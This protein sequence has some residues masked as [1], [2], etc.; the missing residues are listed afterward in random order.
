MSTR[1]KNKNKRRLKKEI[2]KMDKKNTVRK[3]MNKKA[4]HRFYI[5]NKIWEKTKLCLTCHPG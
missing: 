1:N 2:G 5:D 4:Y 3:K